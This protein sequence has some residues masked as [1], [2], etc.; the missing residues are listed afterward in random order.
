M[1]TET[2]AL[3]VAEQSTVGVVDVLVLVEV[4]FAAT[5]NW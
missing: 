5:S 2:Q 1:L 3:G 4:C